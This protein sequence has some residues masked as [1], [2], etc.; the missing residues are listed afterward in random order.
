M[1]S[2]KE[3]VLKGSIQEFLFLWKKQ[4]FSQSRYYWTIKD[5]WKAAVPYIA[6]PVATE[7]I[8]PHAERIFEEQQEEMKH[9]NTKHS[10]SNPVLPYPHMMELSHF[11][12]A[13]PYSVFTLTTLDIIF[14]ES[15]LQ[16]LVVEITANTVEYQ[17][18]IHCAKKKKHTNSTTGEFNINEKSDTYLR[19]GLNQVLPLS[20]ASEH[21]FA[22]TK[23]DDKL[24]QIVTSTSLN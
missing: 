3:S 2:S 23:E 21:D 15:V 20:L 11:F 22:F 17:K 9:S 10:Y 14:I 19:Q 13:S 16:S 4:L 8:L 6:H 5:L 18:K 1:S 12:V 24:L 7:I